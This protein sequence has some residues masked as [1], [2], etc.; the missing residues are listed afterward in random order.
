MMAK[1]SIVIRRRPGQPTLVQPRRFVYRPGDHQKPLRL[2]PE[3]CFAV[4]AVL[5]DAHTVDEPPELGVSP[6]ITKASGRRN[7][8]QPDRL[9]CVP[10][11]AVEGTPVPGGHHELRS[12]V[13]GD[14]RDD[15]VEVPLVALL[16]VE[17]DHLGLGRGLPDVLE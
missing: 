8:E 9:S 13:S 5:P 1:L 3:R 14:E 2:Q 10:R 17:L 11:H 16:E 15:Q 6:Q 4:E 7:A 12:V